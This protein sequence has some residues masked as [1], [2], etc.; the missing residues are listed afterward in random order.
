M[1]ELVCMKSVS[2][3]I[4]KEISKMKRRKGKPMDRFFLSFR[5][6]RIIWICL[7]LSLSLSV[8]HAMPSKPYPPFLCLLTP[9]F[10]SLFLA[11]IPSFQLFQSGQQR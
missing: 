5:I 4:K 3:P 11:P 10:P 6:P 7:S 8:R 1:K 9:S 2:G